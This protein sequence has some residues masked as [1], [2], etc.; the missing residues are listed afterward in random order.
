MLN[1]LIFTVIFFIATPFVQQ[2]GMLQSAA[3]TCDLSGP[4]S[5]GI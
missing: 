3:L 1:L 4:V 2:I 5:C